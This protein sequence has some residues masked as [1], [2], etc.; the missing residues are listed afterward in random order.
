ML[1]R[2]P[3]APFPVALAALSLLGAVLSFFGL[4]ADGYFF[5]TPACGIGKSAVGSS[6]DARGG[7][8]K[9]AC[10]GFS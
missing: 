9:M 5:G 6:A 10:Q 1:R 2:F 4:Y 7:S 3:I 8:C